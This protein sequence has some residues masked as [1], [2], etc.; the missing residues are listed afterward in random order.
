M[1]DSA[2]SRTLLREEPDRHTRCEALLRIIFLEW[3][4]S[5]TTSSFL[6]GFVENHMEACG[7]SQG[8]W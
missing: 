5:L 7:Q 1:C 6:K 4:W 3:K 2:R 8:C